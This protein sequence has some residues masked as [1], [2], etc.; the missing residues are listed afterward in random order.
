MRLR[1]RF[2]ALALLGC[3]AF[4]LIAGGAEPRDAQLSPA[5]VPVIIG[6]ESPATFNDPQRLPEITFDYPSNWN[7]IKGEGPRDKF[8]QAIIVGPRNAKSQFPA[9]LTVRRMPVTAPKNLQSLLA[10][11][12]RQRKVTEADEIHQTELE[13]AGMPVTRTD[14]TAFF[15]LPLSGPNTKPTKLV[16]REAAFEIGEV[17]FEVSYQADARDAQTYGGVYD[18]A[19]ASL[20]RADQA[21]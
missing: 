8:W 13:I 3:I 20:K 12:A 4:P 11:R 7:V 19:L 18:A 15:P 17:V 9:M 1:L 14:Y 6:V 21:R 10:E 2:A 5:E 16:V